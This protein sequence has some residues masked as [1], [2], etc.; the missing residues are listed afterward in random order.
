MITNI[1]EELL[2]VGIALSGEH[3]LDK[4]LDMILMEAQRLTNADGGSIYLAEGDK[5]IFKV[6]RNNTFFKRWGEAKTRQMFKSFEMPITKKS[7]S[8]YVAL[9]GKPLN[10]SNVHC[11]PENLE[12]SYDPSFDKKNEYNTVSMLVIPMLDREN[13]V[14]GILQLINSMDA[15]KVVP[16]TDDHLKITS[17][18]SS[19]AS[20]AIQNAKLTKDLKNAQL[21]T[22]FRL[23]A[24]AGYRDK[25]TANHIKRVSSYCR[26]MAKKAGLDSEKAELLF[27]ASPMH[28]IG[29]LGVPDAILLKPGILTPEERKEMEKHSLIGALI[30]KDSKEAVIVMSRIAALT[31]HEKWDGTGYPLGLKGTDIPIEGRIVAIADVFDALSSKR[32]YK[33]AFPEE[34]VLAIMKDSRGKHFDPDLLDAFLCAMDE[35]RAIKAE[36]EDKEEDFDKFSDIKNVDAASLLK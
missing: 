20:V 4:L 10:I 17:S 16:F 30:L 1:L 27:W 19:Q 24:A 12:C 36:Y 31:H 35:V 21:E 23:S 3:D 33:D 25:E 22:I 28:D 15:D 9:T 32:C 8:G 2:N 26:L 11:I 5:L 18:F 7:M 34:K 29:K 6:S 14:I 13:N